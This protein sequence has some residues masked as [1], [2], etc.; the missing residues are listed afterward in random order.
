[1][2]SLIY[3]LLFCIQI[4]S[5]C[6]IMCLHY[7]RYA[8]AKENKKLFHFLFVNVLNL[9]W[10]EMKRCLYLYWGF[11]CFVGVCMS[12]KFFLSYVRICSFK[13]TNTYGT[14]IHFHTNK[15][16]TSCNSL[17]LSIF[18]NVILFSFE[19]ETHFAHLQKS[20]IWRCFWN[21]MIKTCI[22]I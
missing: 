11:L 3:S 15:I 13:W 9:L 10:L 5:N 22:E 7:V 12:W 8:H 21:S 20:F 1:M 2:K 4:R 18:C 14:L 19:C 17:S 6:H 16:K